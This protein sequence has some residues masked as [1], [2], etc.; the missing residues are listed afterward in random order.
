VKR[1]QFVWWGW[2]SWR[3][4]AARCQLVYSW[5]VRVGPLEIR[6]WQ[7]D[8][9]DKMAE[10]NQSKAMADERLTKLAPDLLQFAESFV[11]EWEAT[12]IDP[13]EVNH[14]WKQLYDRAKEL[15]RHAKGGHTL[16]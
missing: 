9:L 12:W 2:R 4:H 11:Y 3:F 5:I 14:D 8:L 13:D 6:R 1:F 7:N 16:V 10:R 15:I